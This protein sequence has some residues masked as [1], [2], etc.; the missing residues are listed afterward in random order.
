MEGVSDIRERLLAA[1]ND[2]GVS[3]ETRIGAFIIAFVLGLT[4]QAHAVCRGCGREVGTVTC[5]SCGE[6]P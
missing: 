1:A 4:G 3:D 2:T 5:D 6:T